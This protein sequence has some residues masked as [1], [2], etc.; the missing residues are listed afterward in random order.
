MRSSAP[1]PFQTARADRTSAETGFPRATSRPSRCDPCSGAGS[2]NTRRRQPPPRIISF[3]RK[4]CRRCDG[5]PCRATSAGAPSAPRSSHR[6]DDSQDFTRYVTKT[7]PFLKVLHSRSSRLIGPSLRRRTTRT[8]AVDSVAHRQPWEA[9]HPLK[10]RHSRLA[11]G[12]LRIGQRFEL[13]HWRF[14]GRNNNARVG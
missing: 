9:S 6:P 1:V 10:R 2:R 12:D 7:H 8:R 4:W 13:K 3:A 14:D 5:F 11:D